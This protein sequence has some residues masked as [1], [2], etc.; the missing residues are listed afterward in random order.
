MDGTETQGI[1]A[2]RENMGYYWGERQLVQN[3]VVLYMYGNN[4]ISSSLS[5]IDY[6]FDGAVNITGSNRLAGFM[7][8]GG[9]GS[10]V[11][12]RQDG[13]DLTG[14]ITLVN[15][16]DI[17]FSLNGQGVSEAEFNSLRN[18][19][20]GGGHTWWELWDRPDDS[21]SIFALTVNYP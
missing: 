3:M 6:A 19:H 14:E 10:D 21:I 5:G 2:I 17:A 4:L 16:F 18:S 12:I 15:S 9:T 13:A 8:A 20:F 7:W 11:L 1:L